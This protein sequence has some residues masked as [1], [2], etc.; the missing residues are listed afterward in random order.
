[1]ISFFKPPFLAY[2]SFRLLLSVGQLPELLTADDKK[3]FEK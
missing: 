1:M 2:F 3:L